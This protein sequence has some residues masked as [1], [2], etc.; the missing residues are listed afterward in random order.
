MTTKELREKAKKNKVTLWQ[1]A[2]EL[3]VSEAT[4]TRLFRHDL[5]EERKA[6]ISEAIKR[7]AAK[8]AMGGGM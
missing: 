6:Q 4:I 7:I 8:N 5:N 1:I 3:G 2:D